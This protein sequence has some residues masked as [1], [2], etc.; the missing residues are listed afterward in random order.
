MDRG[1]PYVYKL[2]V[3]RPNRDREGLA[4]LVSVSPW[5]RAL[6]I[7]SPPRTIPIT[8]SKHTD[9]SFY[10]GASTHTDHCHDSKHAYRPITA[11]TPTTSLVEI[12]RAVPAGATGSHQAEHMYDLF[13][14][15]DCPGPR[16]I[17][18]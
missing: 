4:L 5:V 14:M 18:I 13:D 3:P 6:Y 17:E 10:I 7:L 1:R 2:G 11:I 12:Y 16:H 8:P 9:H 15:S